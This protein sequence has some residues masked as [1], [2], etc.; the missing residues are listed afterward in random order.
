MRGNGMAA[1]T[2]YALPNDWEHARRRLRLLEE[3]LDAT[4]TGHLA[5]LGVGPGW[6]CLEVGA[7]G[8]SI[9]AW[10]CRAAGPTGRVVAV[11]L[12]TR[13][14]D[15]LDE[16]NLAVCRLDVVNDELPRGPF[17]LIHTRAVL[18]HIPEREAVLARLVSRLRPGGW[19][20]LE[21]PDNALHL[22]LASGKYREA[23][24][25]LAASL[26][27]AGTA[28]DWARQLPSLFQAHGLT[29][30]RA[31]CHAPHFT[32]GS[33]VA[34]CLQVSI[35]QLSERMVA[36]GATPELLDEVESQLSDPA[37]WFPGLPFV[38]AWGRRPAS[39]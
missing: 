22:D 12:D 28:N 3:S 39:R 21:E 19:L 11:D 5:G 25:Y 33:S 8:G 26:A 23:W 2:T 17:D 14:V 16:D 34:Q 24:S 7:G 20:L 30:I 9:T 4:S 27:A 13:F 35:R 32:G 18:L 38:T 10:L 29:G 6:R 15:E 37:R 31:E 36:Q 1:S